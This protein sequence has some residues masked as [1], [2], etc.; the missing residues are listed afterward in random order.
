MTKALTIS[1]A[2]PLP[3]NYVAAKQALAECARVDECK[4][5][6]DAALRLKSYAKQMK[7]SS[8]ENMA[9]KIRDRAMK[10][11]GQLLLS[12]KASKGGRPDKTRGATPPSSRKAVA[13][14]AGVS[15]DQAKQMIRVARVPDEQFE[16]MV[17]RPKPATVEELAAAGTKKSERV[18]PKPHR[19]EWIDWTNAVRHLAV[20]PACG[21]DVLANRRSDVFDDLRSATKD[22]IANLKLWA[23][24]LEKADGG[25][26]A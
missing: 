3:T 1:K 11:G 19:N 8:L 26:K 10:R 13:E 6:G 21:L 23:S 14:K 9:Q 15:P 22:A 12:V 2:N 16:S 17:E 20:L 5:W 18:E 4:R 25:S 24:A 7:D